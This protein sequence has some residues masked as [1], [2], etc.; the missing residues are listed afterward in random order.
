MPGMIDLVTGLGFFAVLLMAGDEISS[1]Q[2][3]TGDFMSFFT[4]MSLT[5]QP[6]RRLG[7]MSGT[8]QV[9]A[10]SLERIYALFDARPAYP[11]PSVSLAL[12]QPGAPEIRFEDVSFAHGDQP[13][14]HGLVVYGRGWQDHGPWSA[15]PARA[16][17]RCSIC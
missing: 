9:A 3:T 14:L 11:R 7:E 5:F 10:A 12:P 8:W 17:A 16:K 4:A 1:G 13:V 15:R 2:R 6:L